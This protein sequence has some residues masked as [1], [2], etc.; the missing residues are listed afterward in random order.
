[1]I[2]CKRLGYLGS[3]KS[4]ISTSRWVAELRLTSDYQVLIQQEVFG[5]KK[6]SSKNNKTYYVTLSLLNFDFIANIQVI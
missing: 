4:F 3:Q 1:M 5:G 6:T 2:F